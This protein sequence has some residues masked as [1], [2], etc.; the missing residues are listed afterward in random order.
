MHMMMIRFGDRG[1]G[2]ESIT[3]LGSADEAS[4][5]DVSK[6]RYIADI[7]GEADD[8]EGGTRFHIDSPAKI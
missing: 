8:R 7:L 6:F 4:E 1:F 2:L 5:E 3:S